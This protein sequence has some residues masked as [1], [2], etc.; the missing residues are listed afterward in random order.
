MVILYAIK[1]S[2]CKH[3][4]C[5]IFFNVKKT[6][7]YCEYQNER[8]GLK[9]Q[10]SHF[11]MHLWAIVLLAWWSLDVIVLQKMERIMSKHFKGTY[12]SQKDRCCFC[13]KWDN[14][15]I[16]QHTTI[17]CSKIK[18]YYYKSVSWEKNDTTLL[19]FGQYWIL[20]SRPKTKYFYKTLIFM[21][22]FLT[23]HSMTIFIWFSCET[24][25]SFKFVFI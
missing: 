13:S 19:H 2:I 9:L 15:L 22:C 18:S 8:L 1:T 16:T 12:I 7:Q 11:I 5:P 20:Q 14:H 17:Y 3:Q 23:L 4:A 24:N 10:I 25:R 6:W 21:K